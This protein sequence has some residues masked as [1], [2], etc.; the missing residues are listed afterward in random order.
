MGTF[1]TFVYSDGGW[2]TSAVS[3][4]FL[5]I[6]LHDRDH[7]TLRFAPVEPPARG[8]LHLGRPDGGDPVPVSVSVETEALIV[9]AAD[10]TGVQASPDEILPLLASVDV[11]VEKRTVQLLKVIGLLPP[12]DLDDEDA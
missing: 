9:W 7:A 3:E 2:D 5:S 8:L 12:P 10:V 1:A 4:R 11:V 6:D